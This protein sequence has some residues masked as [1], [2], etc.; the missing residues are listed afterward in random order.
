MEHELADY[1][2]NYCYEFYNDHE[3]KAKDHHFG[4]V[5]FGHW[6][7]DAPDPIKNVKERFKTDDPEALKLLAVGYRQ[8]MMNTAERIY[9][10]HKSE[11]KLNLCPK[12]QKIARTPTAKQC[13]FCG[14]DWHDKNL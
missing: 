13:R 1:I 14:Y 12:C 7:D 5:K 6:S 2:F 10:E 4:L 9:Q 8:F 3:R 11:L